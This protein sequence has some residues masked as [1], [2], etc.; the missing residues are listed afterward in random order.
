LIIIF[1]LLTGLV[2]GVLS[3]LL[4]IGG[5][6]I[7]TP[8]LFYIFDRQ[9]IPNPELWTIGTSLFCT[10]AAS[11]GGTLRHIRQHSAFIRESVMVGVFGVLGTTAGKFVATS[12]WFTRDEFLVLISVVFLYTG[13]NFI[14]K[15][16][17][18][19][20]SAEGAG[21]FDS[22]VNTARA[23]TIGGAGGFIASLSGL[24]GGVVMVP[25]MNM[26][27]KFSLRKSVSV[28]EFAIVIISLSG[29]MQYA[30]RNPAQDTSFA[31][32]ESAVAALGTALATVSPY[33][34]GYLDLGVCLPMVVAA[35]I[36]AGL[37]VRLH[38]KMNTRYIKLVFG[39]LLLLV[40]AR[41]FTF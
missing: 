2:A 24:G 22:P 16:I 13:F 10:F 41:M 39:V 31:E 34:I 12:D 40:A 38:D 28:S 11:S 1:L 29:F 25:I 9:G 3:G 36:G 23:G 6:T 8:V 15:S 7:F 35:F 20:T 17:A 27:Y 33:T 5:G 18:Q 21:H 4:G 32:T 14:R 30:L 19:K 37:G 26:G